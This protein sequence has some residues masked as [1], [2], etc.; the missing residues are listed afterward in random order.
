MGEN[1]LS[2]FFDD[3]VQI[4]GYDV[5]IAKGSGGYQVMITNSQGEEM[6]TA[7]KPTIYLAMESCWQLLCG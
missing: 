3:I 2:D 7:D 4:T 5:F 6:A 1:S